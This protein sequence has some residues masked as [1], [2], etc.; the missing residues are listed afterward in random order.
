M[1]KYILFTLTFLFITSVGFAQV[2]RS[3]MPKSGPTPSINLEKPDTFKMSNGL[4]VLVVEN[5]K[6]PRVT[7]SLSLDNPPTVEGNKA[8][9]SSITSQMMGKGTKS[10]S[11]EAFN[12]EIDFLGAFVNVSPG[13]G[14]A[15]SLSKYSDRI[16]ELF[17]DASLNPIFTQEELDLEKEKLIQGIKG[18]ENSADA[19]ANRVRSS[20]AYGKNHPA[21]EFPTEETIKNISL[22]DVEKFYRDNFV[23][24]NAYMVISGDIDKKKAKELVEKNF[25]LWK[26]AKAPTVTLPDVKDVQYR[27]INFIDLPNAV[28][29]E[30]AVMNIVDLKISDEDYHAAL[31]TNYILGES[32]G[33]YINM[34]LREEHGYTYGA[35]SVLPANKNYKTAFRATAKVRNMVTD[36]AVVETL[37]EIKRIK[38]EDV[39]PTILENAKAKFL[40]DFILNSENE[41]TVANRSITI[42][43]QNLSD[44]FYKNF[45]A[46]INAVTKEDV[47]RIANK[48]F[49]LDKAR[50][51]LVGKGSDVLENLQ[52]I[53]FDGKK[54]PINYYDKYGNVAEKPNYD[55]PLPEGLTASSVFD[56]YFQAIG[57]KANAKAVA[58]VYMIG[59]ANIGGNTL[60][61]ELKRTAANQSA[62]IIKFG[63]NV[64]QK[65]A[66]N[67][68]KGY[69]MA[70][71]QKIDFSNEQIEASK[72]DAM[73]FPEL[74]AKNAKIE[75]IEAVNGNDAYVI[76]LREG[77]VAYYDAS[78]GLK[79]REVTVQKAPTG[80]EITITVDYE[81]YKDVKG[82]KYPH[83][84][85]QTLGPQNLEVNIKEI[86]INEGV[87]NE[88]FN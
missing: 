19:I 22:Q 11:K 69:L 85:K 47:K 79:L 55:K 10:I 32:F 48:Y 86:K 21:G 58:S 78:S 45:I 72:F 31:V 18:N 15:Q 61:I 77:K 4:T 87:T 60:E 83:K 66:F 24:S 56:K 82:V 33:S 49:N 62:D 20:L 67:K 73:P 28:Q 57:G 8:G 37:K 75:R 70:Q 39:D 34:N 54:I 81:D 80:Q 51:V 17:A 53:E 74:A 7:I 35:R 12:E 59:E 71:G 68:E 65:T 6:L 43:T 2:D 41:R 50:I 14:F 9:I 5:N 23:P 26:Q 36:S 64:V 63:G 40:G 1:R 76:K 29:T 25:S 46:K 13:G 38:T 27:Q 16:M 44:D 30:M 88:D 52:K 84:L 3:K 42:K